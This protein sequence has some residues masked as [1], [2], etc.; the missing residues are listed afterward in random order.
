MMT[1]Q[2]ILIRGCT[3]DVLFGKRP[4]NYT[5]VSAEIFDGE[6]G[7]FL[8]AFDR[9]G[10]ITPTAEVLCCAGKYLWDQGIRECPVTVRTGEKEEE[11]LILAST[12]GDSVTAVTAGVDKAD[13]VSKNIPLRFE[14]PLINDRV[15]LPDCR[16]FRLTALRFQSSYAVI[17]LDT[18]GDCTVL[19]RGKE[20]SSMN[21]FPQG[22]EVLFVYARGEKQLHIRACHRDGSTEVWGNDICAALA[23]AVAAGRCLPDTAVTVPLPQGDVRAVCTKEW[24]LFLTMPIV[25]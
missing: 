10:E 22:A 3:G 25:S 19:E 20:I 16:P 4:E 5:G 18:V 11:R 13:F 1:G 21:L 2:E 14:K 6:K 9:T 15:T 24:D 17:F 23:A 12:C 7:F 8:R